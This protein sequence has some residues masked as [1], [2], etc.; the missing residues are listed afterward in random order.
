M[1]SSMSVGL[2]ALA[3][4]VGVIWI[5][6]GV[7]WLKGSFMTGHL[8]WTWIGLVLLVVGALAIARGARRTGPR[9]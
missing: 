4:L 1:R 7:G 6:Q 3:V 9:A 8:L 5:V 2:G